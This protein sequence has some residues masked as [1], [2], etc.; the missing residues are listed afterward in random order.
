MNDHKSVPSTPSRTSLE[1]DDH[2][3]DRPLLADVEATEDS[4]Q[5]RDFYQ[6]GSA[7][8][9]P[10]RQE[11][12]G[13]EEAEENRRLEQAAS[14]YSQFE[15]NL[16]VREAL[17]AYPMAVFWSLAVS[18]CVIMEGFDS[19]LVP[20]FYAY[21]TFQRKYGEFVGVTEQTKSGYQLSATWMAAI[22]T[23]SGVGA[24]LGTILNGYLVD[25]L[26][27]K[28]VLIGALC[29][30]SCLIFM[31]FFAPNIVVLMIGQFLCG[32]P[33]GIF[34]TV[35][36][37]YSSEVLPMAL[38]A[39]LSSF[40][41]M[42]FIIGQIICAIVLRIFLER[43]DEWGFRIPF[44]FQWIWPAFLIPLLSFAPESPW[45]LVRKG[46]LEDAE[47][48]LRRLQSRTAKIDPKDT[49]ADIVRT[50]NLE[51]SLQIGTSYVDC[52]R[53]FELRR[54]EIACMCFAGQNFSGLSFGYNATYFYEQVGLS[55]EMTYTLSLFGT[56]LALL[57][58]LANWFLVMPY[59]GRRRIYTTSMLVMALILY[60]I[61]VLN[62]WSSLVFIAFTQALLTLVW[63][64]VFQLSVGQLGWSLPGEVSSTRLRT[65]TIC[66]ARNAYYLVGFIGGV[67]Q[68]YM[69]N[70]QALNWS[71]YTGLFWGTTAM[72]T[73]VWAWYRLPETKD[74]TYE[75]LDILFAKRIDA[76]DFESTNVRAL[77][78]NEM[79]QF[80]R[81]AAGAIAQSGEEGPGGWDTVDERE[82]LTNAGE[83]DESGTGASTSRRA[84]AD[85]EERLLSRTAT[86]PEP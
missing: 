44:G 28:R 55:A 43:D 86:D 83:T 26:G 49:L 79:Q 5:G 38:R 31:T 76:R 12:H 32:F 58:T 54:T 61:G 11:W 18:T 29:V 74:R 78:E 46:R 84:V 41:N 50:N 52:F 4:V 75:E 57:A 14:K 35:A 30:L 34:A 59:F 21:P 17:K 6:H 81:K 8:Q 22:G 64:I 3:G 69:M 53:G 27:Q 67:V 73:W 63:T 85:D 42:S 16:T 80:R 7:S 2:S 25:R 23:A 47:K 45:Y 9:L 15:H 60:V 1:D 51:Q 20:N 68:P 65:K 10:L 77:D 37:S 82:R 13:D 48:S 36:P 56:G 71:G 40:T 39:Y 62:I 33:W 19:V 70:P 24:V 66:L 72:L